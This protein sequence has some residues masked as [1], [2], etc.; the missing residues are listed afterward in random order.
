MQQWRILTRTGGTRAGAGVNG[1]AT[2]HAPA[3]GAGTSSFVASDAF[4]EPARLVAD[5]VRVVGA[6]RLL[7]DVHQSSNLLERDVGDGA[8]R[9]ERASNVVDVKVL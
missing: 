7:V 1:G 8:E 9:G 5:A 2:R 3:P 6:E 4:D